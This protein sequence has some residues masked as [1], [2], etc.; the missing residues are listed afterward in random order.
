MSYN[1]C[2]DGLP[3]SSGAR[4]NRL[5]YLITYSQ[6]D[7]NIF[8]SRL[9]FA[10]ALVLA[11]S[12]SNHVLQWCCCP[13]D[14]EDGG[15]HCHLAIKLQK[16]Q[17]WLQVKRFLLERFGISVHFSSVHHNY[18]SAWQ[19]VTKSVPTKCVSYLFAK[20]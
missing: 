18:F 20:R 13:E 14:H 15:K 7:L 1:A 9:E 17:R 6:A 8:S 2:W 5:V 12:H 3:T 11:F 16:K 4:D 19:Y 10:E